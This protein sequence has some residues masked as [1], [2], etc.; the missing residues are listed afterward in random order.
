MTSV[1]QGANVTLTESNGG[2]LNK[3]LFTKVCIGLRETSKGS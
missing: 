2:G 3:R 1:R